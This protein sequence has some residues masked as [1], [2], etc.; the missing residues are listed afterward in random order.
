VTARGDGSAN[1]TA[2][3][4][5]WR[6]GAA[7]HGETAELLSTGLLSTGLLS[8][9]LL[10]TGLLSTG[11]LSTGQPV[12]SRRPRRGARRSAGRHRPMRWTCAPSRALMEPNLK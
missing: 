1:A 10:S 3:E 6:S 8:T 9:G 4:A 5:Y 11:L 7:A 2:A 12:V